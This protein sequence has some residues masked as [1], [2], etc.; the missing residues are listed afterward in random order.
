L[1]L[2]REVLPSIATKPGW[3]GQHSATHDV[4]QSLN[5]SGS[6]RFMTSDCRH[7]IDNAANMTTL[8]ARKRI[9]RRAG[10]RRQP[11]DRHD[12]RR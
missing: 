5:S 3:S 10:A 1:W 7:A 2:R 12:H 6:M 8:D 11:G 9:R 4:K